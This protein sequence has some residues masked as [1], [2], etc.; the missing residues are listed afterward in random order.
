MEYVFLGDLLGARPSDS[1]CYTD[2]HVNFHKLAQADFFQDGLE[3]LKQGMNK[4]RIALMCAEKDPV[5]C[6]RTILV[7]NGLFQPH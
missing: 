7:C 5:M 6:H 3:R 4:F 2:N 1:G